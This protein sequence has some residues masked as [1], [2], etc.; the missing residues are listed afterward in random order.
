MFHLAILPSAPNV[1]PAIIP[2]WI[3]KTTTAEQT[4]DVPVFAACNGKLLLKKYA[5]GYG[6]VAVQACCFF[7]RAGCNNYLRAL[8]PEQY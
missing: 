8:A 7:A 1:L 4:V 3:V 6:G 5:S 2:G